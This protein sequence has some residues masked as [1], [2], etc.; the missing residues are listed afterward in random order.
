MNKEAM[1]HQIALACLK[2][3]NSTPT[4]DKQALIQALYEQIDQAFSQQFSLVLDELASRS[5]Q[6]ESIAQLQDGQHTLS[7]AIALAKNAQNAH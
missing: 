7:D 4:D 2:T 3:L 1:Y 6:L 5:A